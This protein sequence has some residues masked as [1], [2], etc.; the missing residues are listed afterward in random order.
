M[1]PSIE[2]N[3]CANRHA[4]GGMVT[5]CCIEHWS[6]A[7]IP[8]YS[9]IVQYWIDQHHLASSLSNSSNASYRAIKLIIY[10]DTQ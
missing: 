8:N 3:M 10:W 6:W 2:L 4:M 1:Q 7:A 9:T 5:L